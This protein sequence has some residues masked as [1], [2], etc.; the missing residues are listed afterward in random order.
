[1]GAIFNGPFHHYRCFI[2]WGNVCGERL[3]DE[4]FLSE[5]LYDVEL[6]HLHK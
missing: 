3:S 5:E 4:I 2:H 1:M 6:E